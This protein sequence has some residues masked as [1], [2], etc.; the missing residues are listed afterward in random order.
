MHETLPGPALPRFERAPLARLTQR[1]CRGT[2]YL[3]GA[4]RR[5]LRDSVVGLA[6][7][8][9]KPPASCSGG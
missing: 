5:S 1:G 2:A 6:R 7:F 9:R 3:A 8:R 4:F